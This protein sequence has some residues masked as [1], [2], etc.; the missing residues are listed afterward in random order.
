VIE[1]FHVTKKYAGTDR[2]ALDDVNL[3]IR[4]GELCFLAGPSGAG[5]STLLRLL[6]CAE[7]A[8]SGQVILN[9]KNLARLKASQVPNVRRKIGVVFQDFKLLP[10]VSVFENV[11]LALEV[12]TRPAEE[13]RRRTLDVLKQVGLGHKVHQQAKNLSGGEQQRVAIARALVPEPAILLCDEPTGNL[14]A[15]RAKAI[16]DLLVTAHVRGTT[17]VVATHDPQLLETGRRRVLRLEDGRVAGDVPAF[18]EP[19]TTGRVRERPRLALVGG[20]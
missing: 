4:K 20:T 18:G 7:T 15:E 3:E 13:V 1:L 6:F 5:K 19:A 9:G 10:E 16:L 2:P 8:T 11:A 14:D 17:V 12:Q